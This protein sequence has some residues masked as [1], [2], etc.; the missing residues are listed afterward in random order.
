MFKDPKGATLS[1][2][3][4]AE[5]KTRFISRIFFIRRTVTFPMAFLSCKHEFQNSGFIELT[6][7]G[8][9][10]PHCR[11]LQVQEDIQEDLGFQEK[12]S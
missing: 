11:M 7:F 9:V 4:R 5:R 3:Q 12:W 6:F 2:I 8:T 10:I 1:C